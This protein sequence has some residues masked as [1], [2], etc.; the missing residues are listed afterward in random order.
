MKLD[1]FLVKQKWLVRIEFC[2]SIKYSD[3]SESSSDES[4][5]KWLV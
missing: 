4:E 3:L 2:H 5:H 1:S